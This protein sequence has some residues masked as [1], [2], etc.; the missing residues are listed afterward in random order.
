MSASQRFTFIWS[1]CNTKQ[2]CTQNSSIS[3]IPFKCQSHS[4]LLFLLFSIYSIFVEWVFVVR[5]YVCH[6]HTAHTHILPSMYVFIFRNG[7]K[8]QFSE[9]ATTT[10]NGTSAHCAHKSSGGERKMSK[11][12]AKKCAYIHNLQLH[13]LYKLCTGVA[14]RRASYR[15]CEFYGWHRSERIIRSRFIS[16]LWCSSHFRVKTPILNRSN[17]ILE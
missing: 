13:K 12:K 10:E 5:A 2:Y 8:H 9:M 14:M 15:P 11:A 6:T 16:F 17:S 4:F 3:S 7:T 1:T